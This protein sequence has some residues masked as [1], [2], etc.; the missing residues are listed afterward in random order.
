MVYR[1]VALL[2]A[3]VVTAAALVANGL[4][5][6][7]AHRMLPLLANIAALIVITLAALVAFVAHQSVRLD[8]KIDLLAEMMMSRFDEVDARIGD[9]NSGF[10]E[11]Y[12]IGQGSRPASVVPITQR[13]ARRATPPSTDE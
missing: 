8:R 7:L 10:V 12:M 4:L 9:R 11:G 13:T 2:V 5:V 6:T 1:W 3:V